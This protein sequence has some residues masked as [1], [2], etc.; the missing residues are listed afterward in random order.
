MQEKITWKSIN[1]Q[2][3]EKIV[4]GHVE[5]DDKKTETKEK[6]EDDKKKIREKRRYDVKHLR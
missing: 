4:E 2:L 6:P 1:L 3:K 5:R